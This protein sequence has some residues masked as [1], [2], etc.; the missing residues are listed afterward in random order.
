MGHGHGM[1]K[2]A[3]V[4]PPMI[5]IS[6]SSRLGA[7]PTATTNDDLAMVR[8]ATWLAEVSA[9]ATLGPPVGEAEPPKA[10]PAS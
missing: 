2:S 10:E 3:R 6:A 7:G 5:L 9:E 4:P 8:L 1:S